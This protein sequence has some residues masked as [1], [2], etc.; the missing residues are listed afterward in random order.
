MVFLNAKLGVCN[1]KHFLSGL[2]IRDE[3]TE[4]TLFCNFPLTEAALR[5]VLRACFI[6]KYNFLID[7]GKLGHKVIL[8][9]RFLLRESDNYN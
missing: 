1:F 7:R 2:E 5:N 3:E 8:R 6:Q 4:K 9:H